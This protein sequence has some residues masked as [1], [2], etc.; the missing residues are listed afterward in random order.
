MLLTHLLNSNTSS[1]NIDVKLNHSIFVL[2]KSYEAVKFTKQVGH[3]KTEMHA[4][5]L[6]NVSDKSHFSFRT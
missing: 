4:N 5:E 1:K 2:G 6:F 3:A